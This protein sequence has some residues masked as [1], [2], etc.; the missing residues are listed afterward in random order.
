MPLQ[1]YVIANR[2]SGAFEA[3]AKMLSRNEVARTLEALSPGIAILH[4]TN[5]PDPMARRIVVVKADPAE[6]A[7]RIANAPADVIIEPEILH[8]PD[9]IPPP[10]FLP[11]RQ[12]A[13]V[14]LSL[15]VTESLV[16]SIKGAGEALPHAH[17]ELYHGGLGGAQS[18]TGQ[19]DDAGQ[20][21]FE[22]PTGNEPV[23]AVVIPSGR[24]WPM[25]VRGMAI[26]ADIDC[27]ALP[28][29]GPLGWWH[30]ILGIDAF[31]ASLGSG[32]KVGVA[33]T[34]V[35]PHP[36]LG[37]AGLAGAFINGEREPPPAA[38]DVD[39]HGTH[40]SG[41]IGAR[42][43]QP[44]DYGGMAP[45]C[46]LFVSRIFPAPESGASNADIAN[47]IDALSIEHQVDLINLSLG[48]TTPSRIVRDAIA[49]AAERG[50][51]CLCAAGNDASAVNYPAAFPEALAVGALGLL[52]W[53]PSGSMAASRLPVQ[54]GM[55]GSRSLFVANFSSNGREIGCAGPGVGIIAPVPNRFDADVLHGAL[56]GTSMAC[57]AM[58]GALAVLL[59]RNPAY[60]AL[61]RDR[62]RSDAARQILIEA[63]RD[64]GL[65]T[66]YAGR[67]I[68][69]LQP[70]VG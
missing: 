23:A 2:R 13:A 33:D 44:G 16:L 42:P 65:P 22:L 66:I 8:W 15:G 28:I 51:L 59:S 37:H 53:G 34:G 9:V 1:R 3:N 62:R 32:V 61:P 57:P 12:L 18:L 55:F 5:P 35:G 50:T 17:I 11:A 39:V 52:G 49:D 7:L 64:V 63:L 38:A 68:P 58:T 47:A 41:I 67:G 69:A 70:L 24:F 45:G 6:M 43:T 20:C 10:E 21:R 60:L 27:P 29:D 31:D 26:K 36:N 54:P 40:V 30:R 56:D 48:T 25:V 19:T 14:P 4:D 46:E